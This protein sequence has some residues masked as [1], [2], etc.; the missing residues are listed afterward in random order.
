MFILFILLASGCP[1]SS[2]SQESKK[3]N[4][5]LKNLLKEAWLLKFT[6]TFHFHIWVIPL[7]S[8][9]TRLW[10]NW[11]GSGWTW[12]W[13][14]QGGHWP[15]SGLFSRTHLWLLSFTD[16]VL[17]LWLYLC[18]CKAVLSILYEFYG[19][20]GRTCYHSIIPIKRSSLISSQ[21][22]T[23]SVVPG[24]VCSLFC[25]THSIS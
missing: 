7:L 13:G 1:N 4:Y 9:G 21:K 23:C 10:L 17:S 12:G 2:Q 6:C 19:H 5:L 3:K 25:N 18:L 14:W 24:L 8:S 20:F 11:G 16:N 15:V 22:D